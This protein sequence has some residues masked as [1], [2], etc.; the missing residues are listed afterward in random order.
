MFSC[1]WINERLYINQ[2][3]IRF[4]YLLIKTELTHKDSRRRRRRRR[5]RRPP[6]EQT[7]QTRVQRCHHSWIDACPM[8][9]EDWSVIIWC[10]Y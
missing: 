7:E 6:P 2:L 9:L 8:R 4:S 5:R 10:L 1:S 3:D